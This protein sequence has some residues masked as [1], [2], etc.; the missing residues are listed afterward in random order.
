MSNVEFERELI[1]YESEK[2][3][4][5]LALKGHQWNIA[6]QLNGSMGKDMNDILTG[7]KK[8]EFTFWTKMKYAI[9]NFLKMFN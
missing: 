2:R 8:V 1:S 5:S 7:K 3:M 9:N 6:N 4:D